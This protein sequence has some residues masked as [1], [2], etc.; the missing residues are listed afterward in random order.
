MK[1][2]FVVYFV[3]LH[4]AVLFSFLPTV[5]A[6]PG[7]LDVSFSLDGKL[8][9]GTEGVTNDFARAT[10]VLPDGKILV[11]GASFIG[12][13]ETFAIARYNPNGSL[14]TT[15]GVGGKQ[16]VP[17]TS[18]SSCD[19]I[20]LQPDGK[21]VM[22]GYSRKGNGDVI[23]YAVAR[24]N[25]DGSPDNSFDGD[26]ILTTDI[27]N[28]DYATGVKI[29]SDG[30]IVVAGYSNNGSV[31]TPDFSV[32][33]YNP[34]GSLDTTFDGD[35]KVLTPVGT[36]RDYAY[37]V[38]IQTDGK[39]VVTGFV[40]SSGSIGLVRYNT[41]GS[42]DTTLN[43]SGK[44]E[45]TV[46]NNSRATSIHIQPD[47]KYVLIGDTR[48]SSNKL[49]A[50]V[51]LN[52][53][54]T[55]DN[56]FDGDGKA[57]TPATGFSNN[58]VSGTIQSNGKIVLA[59]HISDVADSDL[60]I[61]RFNADGSLD[62]SF[63]G[64]GR[65]ITDIG[66]KQ[67]YA[68][69]VAVQSDGK[70][71]AVGGT[72]T[73]GLSDYDFLT[74]RYNL[75]G[76]IDNSFNNNGIAMLN[77]GLGRS[78]GKALVM[79]PDGKIVVA[80]G[81]RFSGTSYKIMLMRFNP[82]G[83]FDT[84][85]DGD[86]IV[87]TEIFGS[88]SGINALAI[89]PDGKIVAGGYAIAE[90]SYSDFAVM[91]FNTDGS[92]DTT[93][94]GDGIATTSVLAFNDY[95]N[96]IVIQPDGK[97]LAGGYSTTTASV[98][99]FKD[100]SLARF[101]ANGSLDTTFKNG[102][103]LNYNFG[104]E[105]VLREIL[106]QPD[107]KIIIVGT[108]GSG[109]GQF[110]LIRFTTTGENDGSFGPNGGQIAINF[111]NARLK[112][113]GA[114]LQPD[115]K[116]V[117][118]GENLSSSSTFY[119]A[120]ARVLPN[121]TLDST[122]DGDGTLISNLGSSTTASS[123]VLQP[124][125]KILVGGSIAGDVLLARYNSDGSLDTSYGTNGRTS[126]DWIDGTADTV[127][128]LVLDSSGRAVMAG[129]AS[130]ITA[131]AR[132]L[133]DAAIPNKAPFDF[134]GD[135]KT[136]VSIFRPSGGEWWYLK[137]SDGTNASVQFGNSTDKT[138]PADF[139]G[140]GKADIA[141][142]RPSTGEWLI[143]RSEN[144]TF[145]GFQFGASGDIPAPGDFDGDGKIDPTV[146][147]P[148]NASWYS[149]YSSTNSVVSQVFGLPNDKPVV[150]DYDGDGKSDIA[151]FRSSGG[152]WWIQKS[153]GGITSM[154]FGQ[155]GDQTVQG[156]YTGDGKAD[157]AFWRPSTGQWFILRSED[158]SYYGFTY[159]LTNDKPVP[160][161]YDGDGKIDPAV[162]RPSNSG[163]YLQRS[164][165]GFQSFTFGATNDQPVPNTFVR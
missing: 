64:D 101:N 8:T 131:V 123:V 22:V 50:V 6:A 77:P 125:G 5:N 19:A 144:N 112:C 113:A 105:E 158:Y 15:F 30:K 116:I 129:T 142:Y 45:L 147:R 10:L 108:Y 41:D 86:G 133:G 1:Q 63:D 151:I 65:V 88:H 126:F 58:D 52:P 67:N 23:D 34:N 93:F 164:T 100:F 120:L 69:G 119:L 29:Q 68:Y 134:D 135:G 162:F 20:A 102:G 73:T 36:E 149:T 130:G 43:G 3:L 72:D 107:G 49:F 106:L 124:N 78:E 90:N 117:I 136:D 18:R 56:S 12:S 121:G 159:G 55:F 85:F 9:H 51:R 70:I 21:I 132:T 118:A 128:G 165:G 80:G 139:T 160:G 114:V 95:I 37:D 16:L 91:R 2:K 79:Q 62:T 59:N 35:G 53:D 27:I 44:M 40:N 13:M 150:A 161:D 66:D 99:D 137:S 141:I 143:L 109:W 24:L 154:E 71:V 4:I 153:S 163:W 110:A 98:D 157:A 96:D 89:Q 25:S 32:V 60:A 54:G 140:D 7:D 81:A 26:G 145:Y 48:D 42:L 84:S 39:I 17:I 74:I 28:E 87:L 97:I 148:S 83:T 46:L 31:G 152:Q 94:D 76:S 92:L 104:S 146:F 127:S 155:N 57:T 115:G 38:A 75:D 122:F 103:K 111:G 11:A 61:V 47:G 138:V 82:N 156:D 14:D 33:R